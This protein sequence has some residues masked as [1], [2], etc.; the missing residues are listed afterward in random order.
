[1][2]HFLIPISSCSGPAGA[3]ITDTEPDRRQA[4]PRPDEAT[5]RQARTAT[6]RTQKRRSSEAVPRFG[7]PLP[8]LSCT[9]RVNQEVA[10]LL[11]QQVALGRPLRNTHVTVSDICFEGCQRVRAASFVEGYFCS[12]RSGVN[13]VRV[14]FYRYIYNMVSLSLRRKDGTQLPKHATPPL[15]TP[16]LHPCSPS[17]AGRQFRRVPSTAPMEYMSSSVRPS[18]V[19]QSRPGRGIRVWL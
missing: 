16:R 15:I 18:R 19:R 4:R 9:T 6:L 3:A 11:H 12:A 8:S 1:M 10:A 5:R 14:C 13:R 2:I 7:G 17:D